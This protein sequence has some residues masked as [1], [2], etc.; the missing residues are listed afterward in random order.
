MYLEATSLL[1]VHVYVYIHI[2]PVETIEV[3]RGRKRAYQ[4]RAPGGASATTNYNFLVQH[5]IVEEK[6]F[7]SRFPLNIVP[8]IIAL[9]VTFF[10]ANVFVTGSGKKNS[11]LKII[12]CIFAYM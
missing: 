9:S 3:G 6:M 1:H 4:P 12:S 10:S 8:V 11:N 5:F 2:L 7:F